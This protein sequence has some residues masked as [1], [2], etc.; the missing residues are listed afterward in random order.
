MIPHRLSPDDEPPPDFSAVH[1]VPLP[2][3]EPDPFQFT[4]P[5]LAPRERWGAGRPLSL[6]MAPAQHLPF[7]GPERLLAPPLKAP[8]E[9]ITV[10][11]APASPVAGSAS[12]ALASPQPVAAPTRR[13]RLDPIWG[14]VL[15]L[16][17]SLGT[18][19]LADE[20]RYTVLWTTLI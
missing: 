20:M 17:F 7:T 19:P 16:A 13:A 12:P 6:P 5:V 8:D 2:L 1:R 18:F 14:Y 10:R 9:A 11:A 3:P 15:L 4:P